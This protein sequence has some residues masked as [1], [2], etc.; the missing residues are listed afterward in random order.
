M[1]CPCYLTIDLSECDEKAQTIITELDNDLSLKKVVSEKTNEDD[2]RETYM[3]KRGYISV[4]A[5]SGQ[6]L[7]QYHD[8]KLIIP[9]GEECD[10]LMAYSSII[11]CTTDNMTQLISLNKQYASLHIEFYGDKDRPFPYKIAV[12]GN[13]NGINL[14]DMSP[15]AGKFTHY[16]EAKGKNDNIF[17]VLVPRQAD[18]SLAID[19]F[20]EEGLVDTIPIGEKI[21]AQGYSW[22][23]KNL[24]D[25]YLKI[26]YNK[27]EI[28][29]IVKPWEKEDDKQV[30]L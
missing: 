24:K 4:C 22:A 17:N 14:L 27:A 20:N 28:H 26:D 5:F 15:T 8:H 12:T 23:D 3:V 29:L 25:I 11:E 19:L 2:S 16:P 21:S 9:Y 10:P 18:N 7:M 6:N 1:D 30:S 13:Y